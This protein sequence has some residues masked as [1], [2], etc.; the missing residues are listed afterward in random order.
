MSDDEPNNGWLV[1][2]R[3]NVAVACV[4]ERGVTGGGSAGLIVHSLL[5]TVPADAS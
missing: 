5:A 1:A 2:Y 4:V 3:G